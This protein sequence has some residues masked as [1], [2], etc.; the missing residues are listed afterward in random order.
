MVGFLPD[1]EW[2]EPVADAPAADVR[3]RLASLV[4]RSGLI[5]GL[6]AVEPS[7]VSDH[8]LSSVHSSSYVERVHAAAARGGEW[9][10][11]HT[12]VGPGEDD[13]A[14]LAAGACRGAVD[15]VLDGRAQ[16]AYALV[17]PPGHHAKS[18]GGGG[19]CVFANGALAAHRALDR[20]MSRVMLLDWDAHH[21]DGAQEIFWSSARVLTISLHQDNLFP[22]GTGGID[23]VGAGPGRGANVNIPLPTGSGQGAFERAFE[24][25]VVPAARRWP[26]DLIV[27]ACGLDAS[28]MDPLARLTLHSDGYRALIRRTMGIAQEHCDGRLVCCHEGGYSPAYAPF[29]AFAIVEELSGLRTAVDDPFLRRWSTPLGDELRSHEAEAVDRAAHAFDQTDNDRRC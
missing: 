10:G 3:R 14:A 29:C 20:G 9:V 27:V 15:A 19:S 8:E 17:G 18:F 26:P 25:I 21:G 13:K 11:D 7:R 22:A 28:T 1:G 6:V 24:A 16:N 5:R 2:L 12:W 4:E 23:A